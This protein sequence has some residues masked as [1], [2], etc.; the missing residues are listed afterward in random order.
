MHRLP[1]VIIIIFDT[2]VL[3][4]KIRIPKKLKSGVTYPKSCFRFTL[5]FA[6]KKIF[7]QLIVIEKLV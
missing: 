6:I 7:L 1:V 4:K 2:P 3:K 5:S